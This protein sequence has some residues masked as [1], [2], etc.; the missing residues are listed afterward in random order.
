MIMG[1]VTIVPPGHHVITY[2]CDRRPPHIVVSG[3]H[4]TWEVSERLFV[5]WRPPQ[6]VVAKGH[7]TLKVIRA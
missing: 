6:F 3:G 1:T 7:N 2:V 5:N 4:K